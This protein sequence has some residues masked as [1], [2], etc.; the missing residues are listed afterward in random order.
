MFIA[1]KI[2]NCEFELA[3]IV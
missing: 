3:C 2:T 1:P